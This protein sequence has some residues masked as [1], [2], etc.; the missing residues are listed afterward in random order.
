MYTNLVQPTT[1]VCPEQEVHHDA[2]KKGSES[3]IPSPVVSFS[4]SDEEE[5]ETQVINKRK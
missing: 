2:D 3:H 1:E 4:L 5:E